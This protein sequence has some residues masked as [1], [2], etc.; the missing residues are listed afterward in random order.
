MLEWAFQFIMLFAFASS[1]KCPAEALRTGTVTL[2]TITGRSRGKDLMVFLG[3]LRSIFI[4]LFVVQILCKHIA[5]SIVTAIGS[6]VHLVISHVL[7]E[8]RFIAIINFTCSHCR[9]YLFLH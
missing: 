9:Q 4:D 6:M 8:L 5:E 1:P 2:T 7:F 3:V